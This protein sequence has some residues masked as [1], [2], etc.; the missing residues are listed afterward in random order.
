MT[1]Q[2]FIGLL[3]FLSG[4]LISQGALQSA[5]WFIDADPGAG[6]GTVIQNVTG[7]QQSLSVT[8]PP[9]V[10]SGLS[11]GIHV[12]GLR[13]QDE[14]GAWGQVSWRPFLNRKPADEA[15]SE[16]EYFIDT[17]PSAG[18]GEAFG[19]LN[20]ATEAFQATVP[21]AAI[22]A[23]ND[24][25]HLMGVR[26]RQGEADTWG[27]VSWRVFVKR[28]EPAGV[29]QAGEF[30][31]DTD[32]GVGMAAALPGVQSGTVDGQF[33][34]MID[35]LA[36]GAHLLGVRF[37]D[38][39][40]KWGQSS[41]RVFLKREAAPSDELARIDFKITRGES[42]LSEGSFLG[43]GSMSIATTHLATDVPLNE[44]ENLVLEMQ[45]VD[46]L[47]VKGHKVFRELAIEEFTE[48][49]LSLFFTDVERRNASISGDNAD[50]DGD[51]L[52]TLLE[53]ALGL[54]PTEFNGPNQSPHFVGSS[55]SGTFRFQAAGESVFDT[56]ESVF[57]LGTL[58][59]ELEV[60]T[61]LDNW[62]KAV[63]PADFTVEAS[64]VKN[65]DGT[66]QYELTLKD[67]GDFTAH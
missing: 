5:E 7:E 18:E 9:D 61:S 21:A 23:L 66:Y 39:D 8:V 31:F 28:S 6:N 65:E 35:G 48:S 58:R 67:S 47:G 41:F 42:T 24:G 2:T 57:R 38:G 17:L 1:K 37:Q 12:L 40:G 10:T 36:T 19:S 34:A 52:T 44:G 45:A 3:G 49:F 50:I 62:T 51:G 29:L 20:S 43:D 22:E 4:A 53:Q 55:D 16:A 56:G 64:G 59:F 11:I 46:A 63:A 13:F 26:F 54:N 27:G 15:L 30:F 33:E 14:N 32:P 60:A 25:V